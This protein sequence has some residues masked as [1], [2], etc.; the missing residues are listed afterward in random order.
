[1]IILKIQNILTKIDGYIPITIKKRIYDDLSYV[2]PNVEF[3]LQAMEE[4]QRKK[5]IAEYGERGRYMPLKFQWDG[6]QR[7]FNKGNKTFPTGFF[8]RVVNILKEAN[9]PFDTEDL[10]IE[11]LKTLNLKYRGEEPRDYQNKIIEDAIQS[12]RGII[13]VATGGGKTLLIGNIIARLN[14]EAIVLIHRETIFRQLIGRLQEY[15][16]TKVGA[17][18]AGENEFN[19]KIVVGM[20]QTVTQPQY[21]DWLKRFPVVIPDECHR[22]PADTFFS[23]L[24]ACSGAYYRFGTTATP[25][26]EDN[27]EMFLEAALGGFI[28]KIGPS[29]LI[30]RG[31]LT[32]PRVTFVETPKVDKWEALS[33][34]AQYSKCIV[35]NE[36]RNNLIIDTANEFKQMKKTCLIAVT[37]IKHGEILLKLIK[38]KYPE[39]KVKFI[40]GENESAEKQS[41]LDELNRGVIDCGIATSVFGEGID[42]PS[43]SALI[44]AKGQD[45]AIDVIQLIGRILRIYKNKNNADFI[46][47][48]DSQYYTKAHSKKRFRILSAEKRFN[49]EVVKDFIGLKGRI[50]S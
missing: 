3:T 17:V 16:G 14:L 4:K 33:W 11:P 24:Q 8:R 49:V 22:F 19:E 29:D 27:A 15:L 2:I 40:K 9:E 32:A 31:Y 37:Q 28:A 13:N 6:R 43:L 47:F 36:F 46:D 35:E 21:I 39:I 23:I 30:E 18:G 26:R 48:Y 10:R 50:Y 41:V 42:V 45:S 44:N 12:Q 1:M 5:L 38:E 20:A 25:F 7:F 34:A